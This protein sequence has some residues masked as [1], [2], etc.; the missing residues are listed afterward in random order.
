[1]YQDLPFWAFALIT[2][3]LTHI[4]IASVTIYLHRHQSHRAL[5]LHPMVSHFFRFWLWLTTGIVTREWVAIHR[6]HHARVE[7]EDDPHSPQKKGLR[8]VLLQGAELYRE[9]AA[10][11]DTL[12][13]YGFSTPNDGL[14]RYLYSAYSYL[15]IF[16]MLLVNLAL[17]GFIGLTIWAVQMAWI[18]IFAAGVING[19]GHFWGYRNFEPADASTNLVPIAMFIGGEELHNNHHAFASSARFSSRWYEFDLGWLY[20]RCLQGLKLARVKKLAPVLVFNSQKQSI[21]LDTVKAV[22]T[23][24][25]HIMADYTRDVVQQVYREEKAR[26]PQS[27]ISLF[28]QGKR[29]LSRHEKLMDSRARQKLDRLLE[30]S[31]ALE[32]V[33]RFQQ[34][35]Q[36][37]WQ[38]R[39]MSQEG[40]MLALQDWCQQAEQTG[41]KALEDFARSLRACSLVPV[42]TS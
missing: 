30:N 40:L 41:I 5:E 18:P 2:L 11:K 25:L 26:A 9:E 21:D 7:K 3:F 28:R 32:E 4:T 39:T 22:V 42:T 35:L 23:N 8:K 24:R 17:F 34:R 13:K 37:L 14:E 27:N 15:G 12:E 20:I 31:Q 10:N 29:W 33:Y 16:I 36:A 38:E 6:K 19:L 1:M